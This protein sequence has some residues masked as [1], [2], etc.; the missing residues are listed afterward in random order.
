M[1]W[2]CFKTTYT[3]EQSLLYRISVSWKTNFSVRTR[4]EIASAIA[5]LGLLIAL[6]SSAAISLIYSGQP[7]SLILIE[8]CLTLGLVP[9]SVAISLLIIGILILLYGI[10]LF[11]RQRAR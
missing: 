1:N 7:L 6:C 4:Y 2:V 5:I 11:P 10:C 8:G 3:I 9:L